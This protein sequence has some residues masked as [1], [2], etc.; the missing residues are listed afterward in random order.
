MGVCELRCQQIKINRIRVERMETF[1]IYKCLSP[2][3][4]AFTPQEIQERRE[5]H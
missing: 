4:Q 1:R 5:R 3:A 2:H